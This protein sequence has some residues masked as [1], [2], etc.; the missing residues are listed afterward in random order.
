M[1]KQMT[2]S[3]AMC[4]Y[5]GARFVEEQLRSIL[6]QTIPVGEIVICDDGSTD[7]T[8]AIIEKVAKE[9]TIPVYIHINERNLGCVANFEKAI[10]LCQGDIIFL[11]DQDDVW[12]SNKV[13]VIT[14]WFDLH[15]AMNVV[16]GDAI[17][18]DEQG[19]SILKSSVSYL[20]NCKCNFD[21]PMLLWLDSG[22]SKLSQEQ[23]DQGLA[24]E[25]WLQMNRA[26][27]AT[28]ACKRDF[29]INIENYIV[30]NK[31]ILHDC[32]LSMHALVT[33][34][35]GYIIEPLIAYRQHSKNTLG[36]NLSIWKHAGWYDAR[37]ACDSW[38]DFSFLAW[39]DNQKYRI[40]FISK[41]S[42]F[43]ESFLGYEIILNTH[44]YI[45]AYAKKWW[46]FYSYDLKNAMCYSCREIKFKLK[47]LLGINKIR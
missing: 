8:I 46:Y 43:K 17:L 19:K 41:R 4:T 14:K 5:N 27:G 10:R 18:I 44:H 3:V 35:L 9:T 6:D 21:E 24:L 12:M 2:T 1:V 33:N 16:F 22:F 40:N 39:N 45:S 23:F 29:A 34:S 37:F 25:L 28:M 11:S 7:E 26:T 15:P 32:I 30:E 31:W 36:C 47:K 42:T 38:A 20:S 13:E